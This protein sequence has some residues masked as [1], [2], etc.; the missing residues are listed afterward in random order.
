MSCPPG[1]ATDICDP[2]ICRVGSSSGPEFGDRTIHM[3]GTV[4]GLQEE[5]MKKAPDL[6]AFSEKL[7]CRERLTS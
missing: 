4:L 6:D 7:E 5:K 3:W 2:Q 1:E